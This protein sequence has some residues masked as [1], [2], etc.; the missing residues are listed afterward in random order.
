MTTV[1]LVDFWRKAGDT[2]WVHPEDL[3]A[4]KAYNAPPADKRKI[5]D[6]GY[7]PVPW[8]GSLTKARVIIVMLNPGFE[9]G[10]CEEEVDRGALRRNL[11]QEPDCEMFSLRKGAV[12]NN[13]GKYWRGIFK[14]FAQGNEDVFSILRSKVCVVQLVPYHSRQSP[15]DLPRRLKST[16]NMLS[17]LRREIQSGDRHI[18][19][20]RGNNHLGATHGGRVFTSTAERRLRKPAFNRL[21]KVSGLWAEFLD[22]GLEG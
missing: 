10:Q 2:D 18:L 22:R 4:V 19:V 1:E 9:P 21:G 16:A 11:R 15:G 20:A 8:V 7:V 6:R 17:W 14:S 5:E 3:E 12:D 13:G